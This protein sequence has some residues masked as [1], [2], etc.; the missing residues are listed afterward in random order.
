MHMILISL[1]VKKLVRYDLYLQKY[2]Q[3]ILIS[4]SDGFAN[5]FESLY[6]IENTYGFDHS[7]LS[8]LINGTKYKTIGG[9]HKKGKGYKLF[10]VISNDR[11]NDYLYKLNKRKAKEGTLDVMKITAN[12]VVKF[13]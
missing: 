3:Y 2:F 6:D 5:R 1:L 4:V 13:D 10:R 11:Y 9:G 8:K 12:E 7:S